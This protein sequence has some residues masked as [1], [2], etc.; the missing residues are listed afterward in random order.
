MSSPTKPR[1]LE[2]RVQGETDLDWY[3]HEQPMIIDTEPPDPPKRRWPFLAAWS[4]AAIVIVLALFLTRAPAS[5]QAVVAVSTSQGQPASASISLSI[6]VE[7][8]SVAETLRRSGVDVRENARAGRSSI[9]ITVGPNDNR[10]ILPD[11]QTTN[12]R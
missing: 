6:G 12:L 2:H 11:S 7:H 3:G 10:P 1:T 4:A 8:V 5:R 9:W